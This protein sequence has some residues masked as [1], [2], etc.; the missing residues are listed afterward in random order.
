MRRKRV[1]QG[2]TTG[3]FGNVGLAD[4]GMHRPLQ[5]QFVDVM[6]PNDTCPWVP[7]WPRG[8]K[9]IL[10]YPLATRIGIFALQGI[11]QVDMPGTRLH[12]LR[13]QLSDVV[14]MLLQGRF[15]LLG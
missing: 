14:K 7:R 13:M 11:G 15:D 6:P 3:W 5:D 12:V 8:R 1:A 9:D 2:M 10:P 4:S